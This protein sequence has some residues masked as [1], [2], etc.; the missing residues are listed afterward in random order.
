[1][2]IGVSSVNFEFNIKASSENINEACKSV[3]VNEYINDQERNELRKF[4]SYHNRDLPTLV[5]VDF[6]WLHLTDSRNAA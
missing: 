3:N 1:M 6:S 5:G 2:F 4:Y